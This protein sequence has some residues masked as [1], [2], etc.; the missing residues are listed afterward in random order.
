VASTKAKTG[1]D[2]LFA[3]RW[4]RSEA[5]LLEPFRLLY[6]E[7]PEAEKRLKAMLARHW[8]ERPDDLKDLDLQ[9]DLVPDWFLS[10]KMVGYVFYVDRFAGTLKGVLDHLDYLESLGVTYVHFMPCLKPRPGDSDGGYSVMD[11]RAIDPKLGTMAD[12]EALSRALRLRGM[13]V[14]VDLV[15]NHTAKDHDWAERARKG[16]ARYQAYY[17]MFDSAAEPLAYEK[18]LVEIFPDTA[19]GSFTHYPDFGKWVWTTFNEHQWDLNWSNPE[20]FLEIVD[21][22]LHLANRGATCLRL[23]AVA[24]MWKRLGSNCQNQPEV[25]DI[26]QALRA[27]TRIAAPA[28][29]H[30]AEAIVAPKDLV[31]YLG[32]G[33][34]TGREANLAYHNNLMVQYWSSLATRQTALTNHVLSTHFPESFRNAS[35]ATYLRCHDDIGWAI[36]EE[37]AAAVPGI[38]GPGH[39]RFL[40]DFYAGRHAGSFA[41]GDIFQENEATGDRRNSGSFASLAGLETAKATGDRALVDMALHRMLMGY[42]LICSFGGMPLLY[43]GDEI[44]LLN[45]YAYADI[46]A[47]APDNRWLH[48]PAM[49]WPRAM[50]AV[51]PENILLEG[52]KQIV[53]RRKA[54]PELAATVPTRIVL[55]GVDGILAYVK[56]AERRPMLCLVSFRETWTRVPA[57]VFR[58]EGIRGFHDALSDAHITLQDDHVA[59]APYG[60]IWVV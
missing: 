3:L 30:K 52:I 47:H 5:D 41:R 50:G 49:D 51:W 53:A 9:R 4:Q 8:R 56:R 45:D 58:S 44:G 39:R 36:T 35:F 27:A 42:A 15:L 10:E 46:P 32:Q 1:D 54:L 11:Y 29:I 59:V 24:F 23:D 33:R 17:W 43:M 14:C 19:P 48:R 25:H 20:V 28:L 55:T 6:G 21:I 26:L 18:T 22:M 57:D 2:R 31:P 40:A 34:H 13:D 12:F 7:K 38:S 37:D 16:D 60:R